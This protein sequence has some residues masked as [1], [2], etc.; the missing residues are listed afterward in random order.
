[1]KFRYGYDFCK[2]L[3]ADNDLNMKLLCLSYFLTNVTK[4]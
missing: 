3:L 1:M 4:L 2:L